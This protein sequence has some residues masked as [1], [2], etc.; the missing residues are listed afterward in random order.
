MFPIPT[1]TAQRQGFN[2]FRFVRRVVVLGFAMIQLVLVARILLDLGIVPSEGTW[3]I[4]IIYWS[5]FFAAPVQELG[6]GLS[7]LFGGGGLDFIAGG[8]LNPV[9]IAALAGW[10]VLESL[11]MRVVTKFESV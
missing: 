9:M 6:S 2:P 1:P 8:G 10:T 5:D 11:I 7:G 4:T 3:G